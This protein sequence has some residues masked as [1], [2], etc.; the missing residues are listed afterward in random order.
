MRSVRWMMLSVLLLACASPFAIVRAQPK[1]A[2]PAKPAVSIKDMKF[3]PDTLEVTVGQTV[4]WTNAD[5][6][7]HTVIESNNVFKS[8]NIKPAKTFSYKFDKA[9][10][11]SYACSYHPRMKGTI[12]VVEE[13]PKAP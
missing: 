10:K 1:P 4:T 2:T 3:N 8:D 12:T 11:F 6:Q 7:D 9:G 5:D 13:K